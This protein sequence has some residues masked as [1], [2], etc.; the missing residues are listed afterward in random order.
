M[1]TNMTAEHLMPNHRVTWNA[2]Y[3]SA[4]GWMPQDD[5]EAYPRLMFHAYWNG[6]EIKAQLSAWNGHRWLHSEEPA[7]WPELERYVPREE[8]PEEMYAGKN[9]PKKRNPDPALVEI[10]ERVREYAKMIEAREA[11]EWE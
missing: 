10:I 5:H 2:G 7:D 3:D 4:E 6:E 1:K 9:G 8:W 11:E